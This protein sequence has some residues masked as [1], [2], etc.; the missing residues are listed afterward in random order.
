MQIMTENDL[1]NDDI[2]T[3]F[4]DASSIVSPYPYN[5]YITSSGVMVYIGNNL[6]HSSVYLFKDSTISIA[7][8]FA[9]Q[10]GVRIGYQ[11]AKEN[12]KNISFLFSDSSYSISGLTN[13][14]QNWVNN[15][16][17]C[18]FINSSRQEVSHQHIFQ[19]IISFIN[20]YN[21]NIRFVKIKGHIHENNNTDFDF[22]DLKFFN[23]CKY[24][25]TKNYVF[26]S[27]NLTSNAINIIAK[28]NNL[29]DQL[30]ASSIENLPHD[31]ISNLPSAVE[32]FPIQFLDIDKIG[33][34]N[35]IKNIKYSKG[36]EKENGNFNY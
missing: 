36:V 29:V 15:S 4:T 34:E 21:Y 26:N 2:V 35:Y 25:N 30:A 16:I 10:Q 14:L 7:E 19:S 13:W 32:S 28:R 18:V 33:Y 31:C 24:I 27:V 3:I 6:V 5:R 1:F 23:A 8:L 9:V 11:I 17:N 20:Y 12:R 22:L